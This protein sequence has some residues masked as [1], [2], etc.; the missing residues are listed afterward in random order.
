[1]L[2]KEQSQKRR[3]S[4][5]EM[6]REERRKTFGAQLTNY[7]GT[8]DKVRTFAKECKAVGLNIGDDEVIIGIAKEPEW[9]TVILSYSELGL[10][11][12]LGTAIHKIKENKE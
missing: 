5:V 10:L 8:K 11:K 4:K 3:E 2:E 1:M 9:F 7:L 12:R 6:T